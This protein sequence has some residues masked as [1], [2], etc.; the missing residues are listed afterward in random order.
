MRKYG[1]DPL[2]MLGVQS[3]ISLAMCGIIIPIMGYIP[4]PFQDSACVTN[5]D[6]E[7][8]I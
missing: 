8:V 5:S 1:I 4:C 3:F 2:W 6:G 7:K